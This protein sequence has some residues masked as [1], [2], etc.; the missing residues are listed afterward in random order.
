MNRNQQ[1][2][3][4]LHQD[5]QSQFI[6]NIS[7][8]EKLGADMEHILRNGFSW[9][10]YFVAEHPISVM[11]CSLLISLVLAS[12]LLFNF[13][14]T[15]D[16]VDLWV[17][18]NSEA[19]QNMEYFNRH[20]DP[21]YRVEHLIITPNDQSKFF[22]PAVKN[23][24]LQNFTWG[25]IFRKDFLIQVLQLQNDIENIVAEFEDK[26]ITLE[27]I[28]LAPLSPI[29]KHC[30]IQSI[31]AYFQ[32]DLT[33]LINSPDYL[34]H[35]L[36]CSVN[37]ALPDCFAPYGGPLQ[38]VEA[39]LGGFQDTQYNTAEAI[40]I[41]IPVKNFYEKDLNMKA[42][43]WEKKFLEYMK[44]YNNSN[45]TVAYKA[46]R[47]IEDE[48]ERGS[49][50]DILTVA[51]SYIIMFV[52]IAVALGEVNSC[53]RILVDSKISL[54]LAGVL[55]VLV[56]VVSSLGIFCYFEVPA[57][58]IIIE[59]IPFLVL[60]VGVDNIFI[61]VQ[62]FQRDERLPEEKLPDQ[63]GRV[64]GD[65]A[66]SMMLSSLSM[67]S[68]FFIGAVTDM[69][70]VKLFALYAGVALLINFFLQMT[71]F[72][73]LFTLDSYRQENNRYDVCWCIQSSK[74]EKNLLISKGL[75]YK[76]F[77]NF[78]APLLMRTEVKVLVLISFLAWLCSSLAVIDKLDIG[79][80]QELSMPEDS[81]MLRYF[82]YLNQ[83]LSVGPPV[84]FV[85]TGGYN[86]SDK[87]AQNKIC[88]SQGCDDD[89]I[90]AQLKWMA[91]RS[92]R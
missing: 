43:A 81:Y 51:I 82:E 71:C 58:L 48:L 56:S 92:N 32:N 90:M 54:G 60:A 40:V 80:D 31:F 63:I 33:K 34:S 35:F 41:T 29:S 42:L 73:G 47:S 27:D 49:H 79:F 1:D 68:C 36:E 50:S 15:T 28:C 12:G 70:A 19:R 25:P 57:T 62:A 86:Y 76:C 72:L 64:V 84:F 14:V 13:T 5:S 39:A 83:F 4:Q 59:V 16:P 85:I 20:F 3:K 66:P 45:M 26:N 6:E 37:K 61:L 74:K 53:S 11:L 8:L 23:F 30:A 87:D 89:S 67:S 75:L 55:I 91:D 9:W 24:K 18:S 69:P 38:S 7:C 22:Q 78:Y 88:A 52:Y 10:G 44:K 21:F 46:E 65:V 77:K 2:E 17:S